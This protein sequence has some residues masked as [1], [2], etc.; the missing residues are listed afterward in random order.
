[1]QEARH[2]DSSNALGEH[3]WNAELDYQSGKGLEIAIEG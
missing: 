1:M 2:R 3:C